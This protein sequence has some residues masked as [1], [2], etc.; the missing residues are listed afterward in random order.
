MVHNATNL[1][2]Q[3]PG[4]HQGDI[5]D[6]SE[7]SMCLEQDAT[8]VCCSFAR[9]AYLFWAHVLFDPCS[10]SCIVD[11]ATAKHGQRRYSRLAC[12]TRLGSERSDVLQ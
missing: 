5:A 10:A 11:L 7:L 9:Q 1:A 12:T 8:V 4:L 6:S 2:Q 3:C